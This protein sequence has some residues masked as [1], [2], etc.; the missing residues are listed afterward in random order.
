MMGPRSSGRFCHSAMPSITL[1]VIV[2]MVCF[3][4]S[5][6]YTSARCAQISP[7]VRPLATHSRSAAATPSASAPDR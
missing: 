4:T 6:P 2:E 1:S 7:W 3:D 5:V